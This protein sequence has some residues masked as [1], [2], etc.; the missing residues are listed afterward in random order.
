[1]ASGDQATGIP[2]YQLRRKVAT[3]PP[4]FEPGTQRLTVV[5]ATTAL[6]G[7]SGRRWGAAYASPLLFHIIK[8]FGPTCE[9]RCA[10][11]NIVEVLRK[12]RALS[13]PLPYCTKLRR[14]GNQGLRHLGDWYLVCYRL[15]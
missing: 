10:S 4:G 15:G 5:C 8:P 14:L 7:N 2:D 13:P 1:M 9:R 3:P 11:C 6:R 12:R